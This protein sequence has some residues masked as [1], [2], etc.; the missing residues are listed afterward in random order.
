MTS[1]LI[2]KA[3]KASQAA[4]KKGF[5]WENPH[6][7]I[8]KIEEEL[9]EVAHELAQDNSQRLE[10]ELGDLLLAV[11]NLFRKCD[12]HPGR[13]LIHAI[14]KFEHRFLL[15]Q[16]AAREKSCTFGALSFEEKEQLWQSIKK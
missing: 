14:D 6:Q 12:I 2:V 10:E 4:A 7:V 9:K 5:D 3:I 11:I 16:E 8:D 15:M 13:A 1:D